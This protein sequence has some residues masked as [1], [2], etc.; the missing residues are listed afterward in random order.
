MRFCVIISD[1]A[2][3]T[4]EKCGALL[5]V[6]SRLLDLLIPERGKSRSHQCV[7]YSQTAAACQQHAHR[8]RCIKMEKAGIAPGLQVVRKVQRTG[9]FL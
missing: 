7:K 8:V 9:R 2:R 3:G 1:A 6:Q 5:A 4:S